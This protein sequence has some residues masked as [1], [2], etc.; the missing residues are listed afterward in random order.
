MTRYTRHQNLTSILAYAT[1]KLAIPTDKEKKGIIMK[2][3]CSFT[4]A[5]ALFVPLLAFAAGEITESHPIFNEQNW[6]L[7]SFYV[8]LKGGVIMESYENEDED[9]LMIV[10]KYFG[11]EAIR[12][13]VYN[14]KTVPASPTFYQ[15]KINGQWLNTKFGNLQFEETNDMS[16]KR[17]AV[18]IIVNDDRGK[19]IAR[20]EIKKK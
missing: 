9:Y 8:D 17:T 4:I 14:R 3:I 1:Y 2:K 16:G 7:V 6:T 19:E 10:D 20:R 11:K 15:V 13:F 18:L 12:R 5:A